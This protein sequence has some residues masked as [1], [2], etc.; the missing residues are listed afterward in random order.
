MDLIFS[1]LFSQSTQSLLFLI[2]VASVFLAAASFVYCVIPD[3]KEL[4]ARKVLGVI[5]EERQEQI[6]LLK[7]LR[8]F[9]V[10]IGAGFR[11]VESEA[12]AAFKRLKKQQLIAANLLR[13]LSPEEFIAF[14]I[15][16]TVLIP[17]LAHY[18][19]VVLGMQMKPAAYAVLLVLGFF[20]PDYWL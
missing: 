14:K 3:Q 4:A 2:I 10:S 19:V 5:N 17:L 18:L 13:T 7:I 11:E 6:W 1:L 12:I 16:M 20:A 8:P 9:L 15:V